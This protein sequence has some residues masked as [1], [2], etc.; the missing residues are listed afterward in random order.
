[1]VH[2][3]HFADH[4]RR[5]DTNFRKGWSTPTWCPLGGLSMCSSLAFFLF[6]YPDA[7]DAS[8]MRGIVVILPPLW[9]LGCGGR[10]RSSSGRRWHRPRMRMRATGFAV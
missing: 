9:P 4:V 3:S 7:N 6:S 1:M 10:G 5:L 2:L 8:I